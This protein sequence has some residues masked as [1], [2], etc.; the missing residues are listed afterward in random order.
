MQS[1]GCTPT[2]ITAARGSSTLAKSIVHRG[3]MY[4]AT[5]YSTIALDAATCDVRWRHDWKPKAQVNW[6]QQRGVAIKEGKLV[7]GTLDGYLLALDADTGRVLWERA[8]GDAA[9][10]ETFT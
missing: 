10:G 4:I 7:R 2:T 8:A 9:K 5:A 6:P 1:I 3:V